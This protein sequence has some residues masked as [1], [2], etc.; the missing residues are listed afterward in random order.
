[1]DICKTQN[2]QN[3]H[4]IFPE[5]FELQFYQAFH[6]LKQLGCDYF[7]FLG[8]DSG[9]SYRFCTH[10]NWIDF[11]R[12]ENFI[13]DDPLKRVAEHAKFIALPWEQV[14]HLHGKEK[15]TMNGRVSFGLFNGLTITK[16][17]YNKKYIFALATELKEHDLARYLL[18][19]K[20]EKLERFMCECMT[21]FD[22]YSA[23]MFTPYPM[24]QP[25]Y[26]HN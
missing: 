24:V 19:E 11:Y 2:V 20:A 12:T 4:N 7:Y 25:R 22:Q 1:M 10:E 26:L 5:N 15:R 14:T 9:I 16:N 6:P 17:Q 18:L 23:L 13:S 3:P 21:I 8:L